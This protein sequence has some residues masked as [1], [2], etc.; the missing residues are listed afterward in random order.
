[1]RCLLFLALLFGC[2]I[3]FPAVTFFGPENFVR[4]NGGPDT[5]SS[6]FAVCRIDG[7]FTLHV[8]NGDDTGTNRISSAT[9]KLD[10]QEMVRPSDLNQKVAR[11]D[12]II[13]GI[14]EQNII[15]IRLTSRDRI[16][17]EITGE[18]ACGVKL[19]ISEP[20]HASI[21]HGPWVIV[22]AEMQGW[23]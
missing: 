4:E 12:R 2:G 15:E 16:T 10:G 3:L 9:I 21:V 19:L 22:N 6:Q 8:L 14:A 20:L 7:A 18:V 23:E 17:V 13:T 11:L 5:F 1:M